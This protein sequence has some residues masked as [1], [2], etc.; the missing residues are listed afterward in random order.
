MVGGMTTDRSNLPEPVGSPA[1]SGSDTEVRALELLQRIYGYQ[2]FRGVQAEIIRTVADGGDALVLM[3]TGGGKSLCYQLPS[4]LRE[5]AGI[6]V[7]PLIALM[8][9]QVDALRQLGVRAAFV[10]SSL[11]RSEQRRVE[12]DLEEG[13]LDLLYVAP[14]RLLTERFLAL[15]DSSRLAL[16][17][18]DEA[19]CVSQW[20]HDFRP[21][22]IQLGRLAERY[23]HV[24]RIALTATADRRTRVEMAQKLHLEEA[25]HFL[26]SFDRPNIRYTVVDKQNPKEQFLR[27]YVERHEGEAGIIYCLSRRSVDSTAH[28]LRKRGVDAIPY[29]AGLSADVRQAHQERFLREA[30]VVVVATIAFGMGIDKPDVRFV[31]HL[32]AP[33]S[34]EGY[35]Q[36][37]GRAGR[38]GQPADAFMTYGLN[39]VLGMRRMVA[40]SDSPEHFKRVEQQNLQALLGYCETAGCRREVLLG[41]FDETYDGPCG[42]CDTCL[43]QVDTWD[44]TVAAQKFLS[45]VYRTGQRFG[46][47]HVIDVLLG[48]RSK[49]VEQLRHD[50]LSTFGVGTD[51]DERRW[52][53]VARQLVASGHVAVDPEGYGSLQLASPAAAV[54]KGAEHVHLR[55][56]PKPARTRRAPR[57]S[58]DDLRPEARARFE[59]L[60]DLRLELARDQGV[61]PYVIFHDATLRQMA[62]ELPTSEVA[63]RGIS[64]VGE[65]KLER[66]GGAF[67][68]ALREM[69]PADAS[70]DLAGAAATDGPED[71]PG[72]PV[73][74]QPELLSAARGASA[75]AA[76]PGSVPARTPAPEPRSSRSTGFSDGVAEE[77]AG[78]DTVEQTRELILEGY[79]VE[80]VA[81]MRG[82]KARTVEQHLAELVRRGDLTVE[83]AT[84]LDVA[85]IRTIEDARELLPDEERGRLKPL[86][87]AL[88]QRYDYW[89]LKCVLAAV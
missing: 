57:A 64:G 81:S 87:L 76:V 26:S 21:E 82:L 54:L 35:Y 74:S 51:L 48:K 79:A 62:E 2:R 45:A 31:A 23:P 17:A 84:G 67:L 72:G 75:R 36:E 25:S 22:Y 32:D 29:H 34:L 73:A 77:S 61:P 55:K 6:V 4:L 71:A 1:V 18:I 60:R 56:D 43:Q 78:L 41:Y 37:T 33:R 47:G 38:D 68:A 83:E 50:E 11:E 52:R 15:L 42:N 12:R 58:K 70:A 88:G 24:P 30:G 85:S 28:W 63:L 44:A 89:Q 5:G 20:G 3:P 19:H 10:N 59:A 9:D 65:T 13:R 16:F 39:D 46:A 53:S 27:F 66:Y 14:E 80:A 49:R 86:Y 40:T 7:S 69:A 8:Q